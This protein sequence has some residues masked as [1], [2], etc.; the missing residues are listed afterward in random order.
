MF[1]TTNQLL[2]YPHYSADKRMPLKNQQRKSSGVHPAILWL[3]IYSS[4]IILKLSY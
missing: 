4:F 3:Q 1:Q 2:F